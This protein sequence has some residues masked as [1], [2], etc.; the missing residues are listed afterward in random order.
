[1]KQILSIKI[2]L[3]FSFLYFFFNKSVIGENTEIQIKIYTGSRDFAEYSAEV[4]A[5]L[6]DMSQSKLPVKPMQDYS[7][8]MQQVYK[9]KPGYK[10]L[11]YRNIRD[12][13]SYSIKEW[14]IALANNWLLKD[15]GGQLVR[16]KQYPENYAVDIGNPDYQKWLAKILKGWLDE[17]TFFDGIFADNGINVFVDAWLWDYPKEKVI[18]PRSGDAWKDEEILQAY[19]ALHKEIKNAI[20]SKLLICN[21]V[22]HGERFFRYYKNYK[23][24][25][26][27]SLFDGVLSEGVWQTWP[28][29][30]SWLASLKYLIWVE[31]NFLQMNTNRYFIP[32]INPSLSPNI[33]QEQLMLFGVAST[34]LGMKTDRILIGGLLWSHKADKESEMKELSFL[35]KLRQVKMGK[36]LNDYYLIQGTRVY[37]RDFIYGKVIVNPAPTNYSISLDKA[38]YTLEGNALSEI[39]LNKHEGVILFHKPR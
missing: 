1:M 34:L 3:I 9:I 15:I 31:D 35:R 33:P 5:D 25:F 11:I 22:F 8:K 21:G 36:A 12:L 7:G 2:I 29:E 17:Y 16:S 19:L 18:N 20:G 27:N 26:S 24:I 6:F 30:Q 13:Y 4:I 14:K 10:A 38:Y 23:Q 28:S 37:T 39:I 32:V